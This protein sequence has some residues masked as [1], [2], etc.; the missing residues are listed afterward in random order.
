MSHRLAGA[1][2]TAQ[3]VTMEATESLYLDWAF[4]LAKA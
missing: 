1:R 3:A 4:N 2:R